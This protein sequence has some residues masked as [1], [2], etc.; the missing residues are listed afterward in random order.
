ME[1]RVRGGPSVCN[2][3]ERSPSSCRETPLCREGEGYEFADPGVG[4]YAAAAAPAAWAARAADPRVWAPWHDLAVCGPRREDAP[5][6]AAVIAAI[7]PWSSASSSIPLTPRVPPDLDIHLILDNY[8]THKTP[9]IRRWLSQR[10]RFHLHFTPTGAL[11][12]QPRRTLVPHAHRQADPPRRTPQH[13]G[14]RD[15]DP[16]IHCAHQRATATLPWTKTADE[17]LASVE[18]FCRRVSDS[19]D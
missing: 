11:V 4:S 10:P 2:H 7:V 1:Q 6:S 9:L 16:R 3:I 15:G 12:D 18:R 14:P 19:R 5:S 8:A 17:I 13:S